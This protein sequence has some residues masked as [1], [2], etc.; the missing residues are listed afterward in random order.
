MYFILFRASGEAGLGGW[1]L[2]LDN[3]FLIFLALVI[4]DP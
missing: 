2:I 1:Y 4:A 3:N